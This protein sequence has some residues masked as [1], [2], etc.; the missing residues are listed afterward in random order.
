MLLLT[1]IMLRVPRCRFQERYTSSRAASTRLAALKAFGE[2]YSEL[3]QVGY[4][5]CSA[6]VFCGRLAWLC[7]AQAFKGGRLDFLL[8]LDVPGTDNKQQLSS[9]D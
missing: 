9:D 2:H 5:L 3:E 6:S 1:L 4:P 8:D 7:R